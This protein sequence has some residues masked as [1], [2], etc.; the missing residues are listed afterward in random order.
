[1]LFKNLLA[2]T[3]LIPVVSHSEMHWVKSDTVKPNDV[4]SVKIIYNGAVN[5]KQISEL[6]SAIDEINN[7]YPSSQSIKLYISSFGG[8]MESGYIA[9]QA[10]KGS[11]IPIETINAG[12]TASSATL[13]YCGAKHRY[14][15]PDASFI[16]H[17][18]ASPNTKE[19]WVRPNDIELLRKDIE[20]GNKYFRNIYANCTTLNK[21]EIE[22]ILS[23][24]DH[25]RY[26]KPN[27]SISIRL[28]QGNISNIPSTQI[29]YYI[30]DGENQ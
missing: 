27:E 5:S 11:I 9:Y 28:S 12:M 29:S 19:Q 20:D 15:F 3:L 22:K 2:I 4:S 13:L 17:P 30:T 24:N 7:D 18:A 8:S 23:S 6:I 25:T 21:S 26:I 10:I 1:M 14:T 16:L